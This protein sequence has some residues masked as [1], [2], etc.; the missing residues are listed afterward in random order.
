MEMT[1]MQGQEIKVCEFVG[2]ESPIARV[3]LN[4]DGRDGSLISNSIFTLQMRFSPFSQQVRG[5]LHFLRIPYNKKTMWQRNKSNGQRKKKRTRIRIKLV[6]VTR[7]MQINRSPKGP[8]R[9]FLF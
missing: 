5:L 4:S 3:A 1:K 6:A 9:F 7:R 2:S 8:C